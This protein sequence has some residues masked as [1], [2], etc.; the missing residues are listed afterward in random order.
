MTNFRYEYGVLLPHFGSHASRDRLIAGAREIERFG[1]D[2]V[3]VRDHIVYHPHGHEDQDRTHLDPIVVLSGVAAATQR[4][5]LGT[6]TLILHRH[7]IHAALALASLE[8]LA[9]TGRVIAGL[10]LGNFNHEFDAVGMGGWDRRE[11]VEEYVT[12][13]RRLWTGETVDH[14]G[15]YYRFHGVEIRPVPGNRET[16]PIWYGGASAAAPRR[17]VEFCDGF[18]PPRIP[19]YVLQSRVARLERLAEQAGR[20]RPRVGVIPYVSPGRTVEEGV[21]AYN[22]PSL[23]ADTVRLFGPHPAGSLTRFEDLDGAAIAGP[24]DL[25][26]E[27]VRRFQALGAD[28]FVF[29]MRV[30]F[31]VWEECIR[32]VGEEVLPALHRGDGRP[33]RD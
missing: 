12:I 4:L 18:L 1:F 5:V 26:V 21:R 29:D 22:L 10:G 15:K 11:V 19:R 6:A 3:W 7:P 13:L 31:Q 30:Q 25:I 17:A 27:E 2:A 20:V 33:A 23:F 28:H 9:G 16:I 32:M 24:P 14:E 8:F